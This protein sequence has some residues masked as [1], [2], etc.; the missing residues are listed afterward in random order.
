MLLPSGCRSL[1]FN[2][3]GNS[4]LFSEAVWPYG[5]VVLIF[6]G[7]SLIVLA[8]YFMRAGKMLTRKEQDD[9]QKER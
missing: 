6:L 3:M 1:I 9:E 5:S 8:L 2:N 4:L 7:G